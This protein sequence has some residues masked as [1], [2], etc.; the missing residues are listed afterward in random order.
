MRAR[1]IPDDY[2]FVYSWYF[3]QAKYRSLLEEGLVPDRGVSANNVF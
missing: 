3:C 1:P 2:Y